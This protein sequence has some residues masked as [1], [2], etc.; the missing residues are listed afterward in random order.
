[1][2]RPARFVTFAPL[3]GIAAIVY[4]YAHP[5]WSAVRFA[6][7]AIM[8]VNFTLLTVARIQLG[9]SFSVTP[10]ARQLVTRGIYSRVRHPVDVFGSLGIA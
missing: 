3:L 10:Q 9:D 1:M 5:P 2:N 6:G 4:L 7:L 8:V